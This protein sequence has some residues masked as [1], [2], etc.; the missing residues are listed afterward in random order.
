MTKTLMMMTAAGLAM[1]SAGAAAQD[2][3][4]AGNVGLVL[5]ADSSNSGDVQQ[6]FVLGLGAGTLTSDA[7][8][9]FDSEFEVGGFSSIALGKE[10]ALG[11][12]RSELEFSF[13]RADVKDHDDFRALGGSLQGVDAGV[14]LGATDPL[15]INVGRVI[16]DAK[17]S[18]TTYGFMINGYKDFAVSAADVSP[19]L[20][21]GI[22]VV[23]T[24]VH[25]NPSR[26]GLV[27]ESSTGFGWQVMAGV[28]YD[29]TDTGVL[30]AGFRYRAAEGVEVSTEGVLGLQSDLEVDVDQF[31]AEIGY[32]WSF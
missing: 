20:G 8:Y 6:D 12:F 26:I 2:Y 7:N 9:V 13:T 24:K 5:S 27:D 19:Y 22:G 23:N 17:G 29:L 32:R 15:G 16:E 10:T 30:H 11:P 31:I 21:V 1:A 18:V 28:D 4:V 3:Y 25:Y 14:L